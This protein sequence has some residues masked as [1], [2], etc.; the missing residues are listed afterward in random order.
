MTDKLS[1]ISRLGIS[2][3]KNADN[4]YFN[5]KYADLGTVVQALRGPLEKE[6]LGYYFTI[7]NILNAE[8]NPDHW[9]VNITVFDCDTGNAVATSAFPITCL[10][11]QKFGSNVTY[12]KRYLL[13]T[14]FNVIAE[15][16]DDGNAT[17]GARSNVGPK[18]KREP[19]VLNQAKDFFK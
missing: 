19:K 12:A 2:C 7:N 17:I 8:G 3:L 15:E 10:E 13:T 11:P 1:R 5:S 14:V 9:E 6:G 4:P 16:D 18:E